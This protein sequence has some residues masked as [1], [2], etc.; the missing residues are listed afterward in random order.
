[1]VVVDSAIVH[2]PV[3]VWE[4]PARLVLIASCVFK[5][6]IHLSHY[7]LRSEDK[8]AYLRSK[9]VGTSNYGNYLFKSIS[10]AL[11]LPTR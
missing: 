9:L 2:N 8:T 4:V 11:L 6:I 5:S 3:Q 1:M 7:R 10:L